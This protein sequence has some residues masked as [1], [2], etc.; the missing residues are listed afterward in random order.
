M[1][2]KY[3]FLVSLIFCV[4]V[5]GIAF[6][7]AVL[8]DRS[9]SEMENRNLRLLPDLT[10]NR[11]ISGRYMIEAEDY[12]SD[13]IAFRDSWVA[14]KALGEYLSGKAENNGIYFASDSTLISRIDK[15]DATLLEENIHY[16]NTFAENT[17]VPIYFALIPTAAS[18]WN[19]KLPEGAPTVCEKDLITQLY[20]QTDANTIDIL[21]ALNAHQDEYIYYRT[22]HHWTSLGAFYGANAIFKTLELDSLELD[23]YR[24]NAVSNSFYGTNYSSSAAWW[25]EPDIIYTYVPETGKEVISNFTGKNLPGKLYDADYLETKNKYAYFLGG[26]QPLCVVKSQTEGPNILLVRD[27]YAD[28][29]TPFFSERFSEVH[30][31]DLRYNRLSL[32]NYINENEI[33]IVLV[34]YSLSNYIED[35][36]QFFLTQ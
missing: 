30:L 21:S 19:D 16:L 36:N 27:S 26:N 24:A 4:F 9:F 6:L 12:V 23:H 3:N 17:N 15:P 34:L 7:S 10:Y 14:L 20:S 25:V 22:D 31:I 32:Q 28:C 33:D 8:P 18:I 29:L 35:K 1:N 5:G 13:Q 2:K 11:F